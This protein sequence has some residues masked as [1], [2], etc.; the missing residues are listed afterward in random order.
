MSR[1]NLADA[2]PRPPSENLFRLSLRIPFEWADRAK[3]LIP[4][5]RRDGML[6]TLTDVLRMAVSKGLDA[7]E[8]E[9]SD[10]EKRRK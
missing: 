9:Y 1:T 6:L 10:K 2:L 3:A 7:L 4:K 5:I 8:D